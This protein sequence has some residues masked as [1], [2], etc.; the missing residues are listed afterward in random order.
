MEGGLRRWQYVVKSK[1]NL[2]RLQG[3]ISRFYAVQWGAYVTCARS[4][5]PILVRKRPLFDICDLR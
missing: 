1:S 5:L 4:G 3:C 2:K